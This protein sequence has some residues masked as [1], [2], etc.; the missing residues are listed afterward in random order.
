VGA[1][2][3]LTLYLPLGPFSSH[4]VA[5][6]SF[7]VRICALLCHVWLR[8][9]ECLLFSEGKLRIRSEQKVVREEAEEVLRGGKRGEC[10]QDVIYIREG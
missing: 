1:R 5:S 4:W 6:S 7:D 8:S 9:L 10:S 2:A 3:A